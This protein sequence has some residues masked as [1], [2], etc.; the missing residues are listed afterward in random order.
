[1]AEKLDSD[2][3][4]LVAGSQINGD[5]DRSKPKHILLTKRDL[6]L[7]AALHDHVVLSFVQIFERFF[8]G[9]TWPTAMNRLKR[10]ESHGWI[11]RTR[12]ARIHVQG[13]EN[14]AGVV[15]QLSQKGRRVLTQRR[16]E[17][18]VFEK[19]PTLNFYQLDHDLLIADIADYLKGKYPGYSWI[20]GRYLGANDGF[21]KIPDAI[22]QKPMNEKAI[23]IELEL[24]GKSTK[25]YKEI[26]AVL[27]A[28]PRIEQVI[29]VTSNT[30]IGR[31]IM[32]EIEGFQVPVGH[33]LSTKFFEFVR[34]SD[35]LKAKRAGR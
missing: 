4:E 19:C 15:F 1:M 17:M 7:M 22:L 16:P 6:D 8:S 24:N 18:E 34:L 30:T 31:K 29:F 26:V 32:S 2:P 33:R 14:A 35:C 27:K 20:N 25:R 23:A 13:R 5:S 28:S 3:S 11:E 21:N 12:I 10:I 9:R